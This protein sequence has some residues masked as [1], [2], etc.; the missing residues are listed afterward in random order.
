MKRALIVA[1]LALAGST[2][3]SAEIGQGVLEAL[4]LRPK[5][6]V[7]VSLRGSEATAAD[8]THKLADADSVRERTL[9]GLSLEE[10]QLERAW[11]TV[12]AMAGDVTAEGLGALAS[13]PDVLMVG[14]D[15]PTQAHL[16]HSVP[17]IHADRVQR[18][19]LTGKGVIVAVLDTGV[20]AQHP[21]LAGGIIGEECFCTTATGAGCCPNGKGRQSGAGSAAD[22]NGHGTNVTSILA[23]RGKVASLGVAPDADVVA[24]KVLDRNGAGSST[25]LVSALDYLVTSRPDVKVV[26]VSLGF[27]ELFAGTCDTASAATQALSSAIG[28]LRARGV[29]VFASTGNEGSSTSLSAPA[30]VSSAIAVG[31]VYAESVGSVTFGCTDAST[32][33]DQMLCF[34]NSG[35]KV[36]LL[37]PGGPITAS[38]RGGGVVTMVGTSQATPHAAG[39]A[40]VLLEGNRALTASR[41]ESAFRSTGPVIVDPK[42]GLQLHRLD[43]EAAHATTR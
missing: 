33:P 21:D 10:F 31:G 34:S 37:A 41:I 18:S 13:D 11:R 12:T 39:A 23:G 42:N 7:V 9:S 29:A 26:N 15:T 19:G 16:A 27:Q 6:R 4:T 14:L 22:D 32:K 17:M 1:G 43:L 36:A 38:K 35:S 8:L 5:V 3:E 28:S 40:A 24:L 2:G 30:C 20:D 25:D